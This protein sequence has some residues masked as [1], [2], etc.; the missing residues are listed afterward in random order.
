MF[1]GR[2]SHDLP[3]EQMHMAADASDGDFG[4]P[5]YAQFNPYETSSS[6]YYD[7]HMT[8]K[9]KSKKRSKDDG[10]DKDEESDDAADASVVPAAS[11]SS[12]AP[13]RIRTAAVAVDALERHDKPDRHEWVSELRREKHFREHIA[14]PGLAQQF[15]QLLG[16]YRR[17]ALPSASAAQ[18]IASQQPVPNSLSMYLLEPD[19][20]TL[21]HTLQPQIRLFGSTIEGHSVTVLVNGFEP[22][23]YVRINATLRQRIAAVVA[24]GSTQDSALE[25]FRAW[26]NERA[27]ARDPSPPASWSAAAATARGKYIM[28]VHMQSNRSLFGYE[29]DTVGFLRIVTFQPRH[30]PLARDVL[31]GKAPR[32]KSRFGGGGDDDGGGDGEDDEEVIE[33]TYRDS[34]Q[35]QLDSRYGL[36]EV[37]EADIAYVLNFLVSKN[38][39]GCGWLRISNINCAR[40]VYD[41]AST[42]DPSLSRTQIELHCNVSQ[43]EAL[44]DKNDVP[45]LR[46]LSI[47]IECA[48]KEGRFPLPG[49]DPIIC[50]TAIVHRLQDGARP[51]VAVGM[52]VGEVA[53]TTRP[54]IKLQ[55]GAKQPVVD[56]KTGAWN[57]AAEIDM[58]LAFRAFIVDIADPDFLSG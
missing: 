51:L 3:D 9:K 22:C 36:F 27:G 31:F 5:S 21:Y 43:I 57:R 48:G 4:I 15:E 37:F 8:K 11:S 45:P 26:L 58:L 23:F 32:S 41:P 46:T 29:K 44:S 33:K 16:P 18:Y 2:Q 10:D 12:S 17:P 6:D 34:K 50:L 39:K 56:P 49:E 47:D 24:E 28:S 52:A 38:I 14:E 55:F 7:S 13:K 54:Y 42:R 1:P 53:E 25:A 30:V 35:S 20:T 40:D 19:Y